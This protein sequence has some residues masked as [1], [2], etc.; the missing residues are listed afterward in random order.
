MELANTLF[1]RARVDSKEAASTR[2][3]EAQAL[4]EEGLDMN[5]QSSA[6]WYAL[7][8]IND[9]LGLEGAAE[10]ARMQFQLLRPDDNAQE[11]AILLARQASPIADHAAEPIAIYDLDAQ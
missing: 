6:I 10:E 3:K 8:R 5:P 9:A 2:L 7:S 4:C 11:K 1:E